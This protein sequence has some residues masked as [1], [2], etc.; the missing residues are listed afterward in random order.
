MDEPPPT[1]S[2]CFE[3]DERLDK[4]DVPQVSQSLQSES[5]DPF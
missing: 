4:V 5:V 3:Q 1:E 2:R